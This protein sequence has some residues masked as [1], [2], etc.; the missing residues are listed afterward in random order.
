MKITHVGYGI[1][2]AENG[3]KIIIDYTDD[4]EMYDFL[5]GRYITVLEYD[6]NDDPVEIELGGHVS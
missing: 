2:Y 5:S 1:C 6:D 4:G 3:T